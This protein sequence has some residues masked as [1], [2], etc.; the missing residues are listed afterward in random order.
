MKHDDLD[1]TQYMS[2][3][4]IQQLQNGS[5]QRRM[6]DTQEMLPMNE[7]TDIRPPFPQ[8]TTAPGGVRELQ[9]EKY[10]AGGLSGN[11]RKKKKFLNAKR[12]KALLLGGGFAVAL[13]IGFMLAGYSQDRSAEQLQARQQQEQN[14]KDKEKQLADQETDLK[15]RRQELEQQKQ[16]LQERQRVLEEQSS[17][18]KGRNEQI[19]ENTPGTTLGKLVDKVTGKEAERQ[20][21]IAQNKQ[22][23]AQS[24]TDAAEVKRSIEE[25]Q[26]ML[27]EVNSNIDKIAS[28]KREANQLREKAAATY[29]ENKGVIDQVVNYARIGVGMLESWLSR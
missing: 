3:D 6:S 17:R 24:D 18:A 4:D 5:R 1:K 2:P 28:M 16:E 23:S 11:L 20:Q 26:Q 19:A 9:P 7:G 8:G 21:Q 12:K 22:Q 29:E 13:F 14:L 27:D 10:G 15:A 25:A